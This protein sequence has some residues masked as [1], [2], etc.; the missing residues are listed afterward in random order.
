MAR[1]VVTETRALHVAVRAFRD[2]ASAEHQQAAQLSFKSA[3]LAW[4]RARAFRSGPFASTQAFQRAAFWPASTVAIEAVLA[5]PGAID[6][7]LVEG[8]GVDARGLYA[9]E[10]LL[11]GDAIAPVIAAMGDQG[12]RVRAYAVEL[13]SNVL[14]YA[15]RLGRTLGDGQAFARSFADGGQAS[16]NALTAQNLDSLEMIRGKLVRVA[17]AVDAHAPLVTAVEGYFSR[18][19]VDIAQALLSGTRQLYLGGAGGGLAELVAAASPEIDQH[20]RQCFA[21]ADARFGALPRALE[22]AFTTRPGAFHAA[23]ASLEALQHVLKV[24]MLSALES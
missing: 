17:R 16:V 3:A 7:S 15:S 23:S 22:I 18:A 13:S 6:E 14:G 12:L 20:V 4:K 21:D 8:L 5:A 11:F 24:E 9:L 10:Y 2:D 1:D 19:S